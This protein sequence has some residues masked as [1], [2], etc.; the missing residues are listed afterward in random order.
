MEV[1]DCQSG[2]LA[3]GNSQPDN[4][5]MCQTDEHKAA[6]QQNSVDM[7][8][9]LQGV[10]QEVKVPCVADTGKSFLLQSKVLPYSL[11]FTS[12]RVMSLS[13]TT[14]K[15]LFMAFPYIRFSSYISS[16]P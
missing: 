7:M 1:L 12:A 16:A 14:D 6:E 4:S 15:I 5:D 2:H 13:S 9:Q 11:N 3:A 8:R 10:R